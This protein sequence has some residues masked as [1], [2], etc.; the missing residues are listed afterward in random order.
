MG[1]RTTCVG[2][3]EVF[4]VK[5]FESD[6][7]RVSESFFRQVEVEHATVHAEVGGC[8]G[9][10]HT[11]GG[12]NL[13]LANNVHTVEVGVKS[14]QGERGLNVTCTLHAKLHG[15]VVQTAKVNFSTGMIFV[16]RDFLR[17][18]TFLVI[19]IQSEIAFLKNDST[20]L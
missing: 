16:N 11:N 15:V 14:L 13:I 3:I 1:N 18:L 5:V 9:L 8:K 10:V 19:N 6:G 12:L 17:I 2:V 4:A 7:Y 20:C